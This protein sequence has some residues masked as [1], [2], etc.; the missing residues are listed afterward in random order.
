MIDDVRAKMVHVFAVTSVI[1]KFVQI[2][3]VQIWMGK[4]LAD[5]F[6]FTKF[7]EGFSHSSFT[8]CSTLHTPCAVGAINC[9]SFAVAPVEQIK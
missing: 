1:I 3:T 8:L 4:T 2:L 6:E 7:A 5:H 9:L